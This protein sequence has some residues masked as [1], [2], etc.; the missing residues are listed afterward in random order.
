M[1]LPNTGFHEVENADRT[2][3]NAMYRSYLL[4]PIRF[5][6]SLVPHAPFPGLPEARAR[7]PRFPEV[8]FRADAARV[9]CRQ[10]IDQLGKGDADDRAPERAGGWGAGRPWKAAWK[11]P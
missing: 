3:G 6:H 7:L 9:H 1:G 4:D 8:V 2:G 11:I 5:E 10:E